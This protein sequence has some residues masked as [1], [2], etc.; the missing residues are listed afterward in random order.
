MKQSDTPVG[1]YQVWHREGD[2]FRQ[3]GSLKVANLLVAAEVAMNRPSGQWMDGA[4]EDARPTRTGDVLVSPD[5]GAFKLVGTEHGFTFES[6]S[7]DQLRQDARDA[8]EF[9]EEVRD[10]IKTALAGGTSFRQAMQ[11]AA[12]YGVKPEGVEEIRKE[13]EQEERER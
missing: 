5:G 3:V 7:F 4:P 1:A 12:S 13:V 8:G 11:E 10:G 9:R 6:V 2:E